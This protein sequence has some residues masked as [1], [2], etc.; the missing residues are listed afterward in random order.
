[1]TPST[2]R[3]LFVIRMWQE[4]DAVT[5]TIQWRGSVQCGH[6]QQCHYFTRLADLLAFIA[7]QT[8]DAAQLS[9]A[10]QGIAPSTPSAAQ[11]AR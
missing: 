7:A 8:E 11:S 5:G 3:R 9:A 1:M 6:A 4:A 10:P 2:S